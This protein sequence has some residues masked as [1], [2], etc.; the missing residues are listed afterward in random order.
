MSAMKRLLEEYTHGI[1]AFLFP[2]GMDGMS[3]KDRGRWFDHAEEGARKMLDSLG[4]S[5]VVMGSENGK[6]EIK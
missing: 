3:E 5:D 1:L 4:R 6:E 2:D